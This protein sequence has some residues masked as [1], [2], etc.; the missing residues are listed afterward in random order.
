MPAMPSPQQE[1]AAATTQQSGAPAAPHH[2]TS[3][4]VASHLASAS[5]QGHARSLVA[6]SMHLRPVEPSAGPRGP[7]VGAGMGFGHAAEYFGMQAAPPSVNGVNALRSL[8]AQP[9]VPMGNTLPALGM[10]QL[11]SLPPESRG[12]WGASGIV[13]SQPPSHLPSALTSMLAPSYGPNR[14][15]MPSTASSAPRFTN[16]ALTRPAPPVRNRVIKINKVVIIPSPKYERYSKYLAYACQRAGL[17]VPGI[18]LETGFS[19]EVVVQT[20]TSKFGDKV[21]FDVF[22]FE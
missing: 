15:S 19:K 21:D 3:T 2:T 5:V 14:A 13:S 1:A 4:A 10:P 11:F 17:A 16:S 20:L 6:P 12:Q 8:A 18:A 22:P 9:F 7:S